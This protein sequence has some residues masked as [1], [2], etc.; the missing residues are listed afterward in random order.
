MEK[1]KCSKFHASKKGLNT[2]NAYIDYC[3]TDTRQGSLVNMLQSK[4]SNL[5]KENKTR[6]RSSF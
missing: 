1:P 2:N 4:D 5:A 6:F 3:M